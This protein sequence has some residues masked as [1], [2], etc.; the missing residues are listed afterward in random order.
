MAEVLDGMLK[1]NSLGYYVISK[2]KDRYDGWIKITRGDE[3]GWPA[4][5]EPKDK[6]VAKAAPK[7][8]P[9]PTE[10]PADEPDGRDAEKAAAS[11]LEFARSLLKDGKTDRAKQRFQE[12]V[13]QYPNTKAAEEA[14][15]E[16]EKLGK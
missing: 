4:G 11:K 6:A 12:I 15:K 2:D 9:E 10:K 5:Q 7:A 14:K 8:A 3:R 13:T 1:K 16:L